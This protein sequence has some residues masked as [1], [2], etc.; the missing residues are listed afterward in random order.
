MNVVPITNQGENKQKECNDEKAGSLRSINR[1]PAW[2]GR[3]IVLQWRRNHVDILA[4]R[5]KL[6]LPLVNQSRSREFRKA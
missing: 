3:G 4:L 6:R 2:L 5:S 1:V